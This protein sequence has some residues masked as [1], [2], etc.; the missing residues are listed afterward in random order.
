MCPEVCNDSGLCHISV[1]ARIIEKEVFTT[2]AGSK[3]EYNKR[4][5]CNGYKKRCI[6]KIPAGKFRHDGAEHR[7]Y[8]GD[9]K[10]NIHTCGVKCKSWC[11][12]LLIFYSFKI[13]MLL[14]CNCLILLYI[15]YSVDISVKIHMIIIGKM[16]HFMI[17]CM[18]I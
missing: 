9:A 10:D 14:H 12:T 4:A 16:E 6:K 15:V 2:G 17:V 3:F 13:W 11:A 1:R 8:S 18:E 7:C 5:E